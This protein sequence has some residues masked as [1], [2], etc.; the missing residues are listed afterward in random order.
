MRNQSVDTKLTSVQR[1]GYK[2]MAFFR[3]STPNKGL[4]MLFNIMPIK[5][6]LLKTATQS[7]FRTLQVA[8]Y[9]WEDLQTPVL[10]RI[11]H[12]TWIEEFI[13]D[14]ELNYLKDP[15]DS[16]ALHRKWHRIFL[17]D[18]DSMNHASDS[19]K[20]RLGL[21]RSARAQTLRCKGLNCN[22]CITVRGIW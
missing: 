4:D 17:V 21:L 15:L 2:L 8:P 6:H 13:G 12:R 19:R 18:M 14:F 11:S 1:L 3:R 9:E 22:Y 20:P 5:Y 16:V 10:A 7:Y